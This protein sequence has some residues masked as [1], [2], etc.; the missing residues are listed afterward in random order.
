M[1]NKSWS[2]DDA[3]IIAKEAKYTF[4]KPSKKLIAKLQIGNLVKLIFKFENDQSEKPG[5]ERMWVEITE[6]N[7]GKFTGT[8]ANDPYYIKDL[9]HRDVLEF[10]QA[11]RKTVLAL[12]AACEVVLSQSLGEVCLK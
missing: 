2:L 4:Y 5:S 7:N 10:G 1:E 3:E 8:L 12:T 6:I 9:K 11:V